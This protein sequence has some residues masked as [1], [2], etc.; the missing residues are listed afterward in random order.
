MPVV[1]RHF[2]LQ[3]SA[4]PFMST[5]LNPLQIPNNLAEQSV[6]IRL[7]S[8][9]LNCRERLL[10]RSREGILTVLPGELR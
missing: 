4:C 2:F 10:D 5:H 7:K 8:D 9:P 1:F 6:S 3:F